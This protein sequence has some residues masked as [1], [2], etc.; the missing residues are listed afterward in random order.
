MRRYRLDR[1]TISSQPNTRKQNDGDD[2]SA[3]LA[4]EPG[5]DV[6]QLREDPLQERCKGNEPALPIHSSLRAPSDSS[7]ILS[8]GY[9]L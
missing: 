7:V 3:D 4:D 6:S 1:V 5:L 2:L 9:L 8:I